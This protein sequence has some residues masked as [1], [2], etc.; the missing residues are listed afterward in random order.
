MTSL[1]HSD[2]SAES[3]FLS[4]C[5]NIIAQIIEDCHQKIRNLN[6]SYIFCNINLYSPYFIGRFMQKDNNPAVLPENSR[7]YYHFSPNSD[8]PL[9][10]CPEVSHPG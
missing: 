2:G 6:I 5:I 7:V 9:Q 1:K 3:A 10:D 8:H 4:V